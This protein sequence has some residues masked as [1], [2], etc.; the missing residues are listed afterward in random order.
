MTDSDPRTHSLSE[1]A[2]QRGP[3]RP[4]FTKGGPPNYVEK[5]LAAAGE[6]FKGITSDGNVIPGLFG[7]QKT[8]ISTQSI[9]EA[10]EA[11]LGSLNTEQRS[12]T[13][14]AVD[15]DQW[16]K[17]SNIHPTLMRHGTPLFQMTDAQRDCAFALLRESLSPHGFEEALDIMHL[18]ETVQELTGR[19]DE[20]GEDLYWLSI[21]G[22]PSATEP[23]GWQWDG[24]H[25]IINY[26]VLGDQIVVTPTFLGAEPVH[27]QSGKYTGLRVFK[28]DEDRGL[29]LA[30]TLSETQ[31]AKT[32]IVPETSGEDFATAF[33]D[34]LVLD[35]KGIRYDELSTAQHDLA[36]NLIDYHVSRMRTD[37]AQV[38]MAEVKRHLQDT[39]FCWMGGMEN[40][41]TFYYRVQSPVIIVEFDHQRGIAFR[42]R[43]KP[44]KDHIHVIVRT[45]NGNDYGKDLLRQHY[46]YGHHAVRS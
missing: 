8:G 42:E 15:T 2:A 22:T 20:Y 35:Y 33:R 13:L 21:M 24:H 38:K 25:L 29:A 3:N 9:R 17:W 40:D 23:W 14:F 45:P 36:L 16:R 10:A 41:S 28:A 18:N 12:K 1:T 11:F 32:V 27:A 43:T 31:R 37:H 30:R 19:L 34:N 39:Y 26:F 4:L 46:L 5:S 6:V 7:T 44:Y